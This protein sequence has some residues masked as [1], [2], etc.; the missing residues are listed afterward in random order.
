MKSMFLTC[1]FCFS[2]TG[3]LCRGGWPPLS[4]PPASFLNAGLTVMSHHSSLL[5]VTFSI[6][7]GIEAR[8]SQA[9]L[10]TCLATGLRV[11]TRVSLHACTLTEYARM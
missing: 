4:N 7:G 3:S 1:Y 9:P 10:S 6:V 5:C 11:V 8:E 2:E